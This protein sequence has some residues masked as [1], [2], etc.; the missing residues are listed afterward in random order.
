V[1]EEQP[2]VT[3]VVVNYNAGPGLADCVRSVLDS[4]VPSHV[5]V[6]DNASTDDSLA[7]LQAALGE[8]PG[9]RVLRNDRNL[10]F[11][12]AANA[13]ARQAGTP[14]VLLLNPDC[15]LR[16]GALP[17]LL[18][19]LQADPKAGLAAPRVVDARGRIEAA[20]LRR[21]PRPWNSLV[22][23]T[24]LW[25]LGRW[26]PGFRG[27][28]EPSVKAVD[29]TTIAEAVSGACMLLQAE[30]LSEVGYLDEAYGLHCEDLDLMYR[31]RQAG[32]HCLYVPSADAVHR[33]G[34][35]SRS[36][37]LWVH[38]QKHLGMARFYGKFLAEHYP[39]PLAWLVMLGIWL[40][41]LLLIPRV[42]LRR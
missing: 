38:R 39:R 30:A 42:W 14:W 5:L 2:A 37:P 19:A 21:F 7:S 25:R 29:E 15:Q 22:T 11:A 34:Q 9:L 41:Y 31:L 16:P 10:G 27:V 12:R 26:L 33:Q 28:P 18:R 32:W 24:G 1:A 40:H 3:A 13:C 6:A 4:G 36:R 23:V 35:S 8:R 20:S 17:A